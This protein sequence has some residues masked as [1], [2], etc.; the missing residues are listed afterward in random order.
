VILVT[1]RQSARSWNNGAPFLGVRETHGGVFCKLECQMLCNVNI[2]LRY[3]YMTGSLQSPL[4][5]KYVICYIFR[6]GDDGKDFPLS[7]LPFDSSKD[8]D[9]LPVT[10]YGRA[11]LTR[12]HLVSLLR[13]TRSVMPGLGT[14]HHQS[15]GRMN[16]LISFRNSVFSF[17]EPDS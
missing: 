9:P 12:R 6:H 8:Q 14:R 10:L 7:F 2:E 4:S 3:V 5:L 1:A 17:I 13:S 16:A 11:N 15:M